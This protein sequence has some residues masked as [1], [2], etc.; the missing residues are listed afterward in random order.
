MKL[1]VTGHRPD[2]N[3]KSGKWSDENLV[4][5]AVSALRELNPSVV[6]TGMALGWDN[7]VAKACIKLKIPFV[8]VIPFLGQESKWPENKQTEYL[9]LLDKANHWI[10]SAGIG[11]APWKMHKRNAHLIEF[12]EEGLA[13]YDESKPTGGTASCVKEAL[14]KG[15]K[16]YNAW[17]LF[18][19]GDDLTTIS[20]E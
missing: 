3:D 1:F 16:M 19:G 14:K 2:Y 8:S 9:L 20:G 12:G 6:Y 10:V 18:N 7:A 4:A 13:L 5:V 17:G 11:Y 15:R